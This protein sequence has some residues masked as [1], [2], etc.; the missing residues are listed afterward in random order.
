MNAD[1]TDLKKKKAKKTDSGF[2]SFQIRVIR[3]NPRLIALLDALNAA[4]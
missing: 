1:G 3:V 4:C 2:L